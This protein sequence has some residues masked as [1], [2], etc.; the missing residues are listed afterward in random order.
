MTDL[1]IRHARC[2]ATLDAERREVQRRDLLVEEPLGLGLLPLL[3]GLRRDRR[4]LDA[5]VA[6]LLP[7]LLDAYCLVPRRASEGDSR[8]ALITPLAP[9]R[10]SRGMTRLDI[11][12]PRRP[13]LGA[14]YGGGG[15][16]ENR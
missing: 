5:L 15:R 10:Y 16:E 9:G 14:Q 3:E 7:L 8:P 4:A 6:E 12:F 13:A 1:V 2:V 11:S